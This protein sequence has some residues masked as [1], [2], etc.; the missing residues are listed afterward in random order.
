MN[1]VLIYFILDQRYGDD[2]IHNK[3]IF[4]EYKQKIEEFAEK[5][6]ISSIVETEIK[7]KCILDWVDYLHKH[8]YEEREEESS[9]SEKKAI[10]SQL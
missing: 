10:E 4:D 2:G 6:I 7:E 1:F 8:T 9:T 3:L 5:Y